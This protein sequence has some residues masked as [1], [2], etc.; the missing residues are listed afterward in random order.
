MQLSKHS[1]L[2]KDSPNIGPFGV[3]IIKIIKI[4]QKATL[5]PYLISDFSKLGV[6]K[7]WERKQVLPNN[8]SK[9]NVFWGFLLQTLHELYERTEYFTNDFWCIETSELS[10]TRF[11]VMDYFFFELFFGRHSGTGGFSLLSVALT[12]NYRQFLC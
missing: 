12:I 8:T 7:F 4:T 10:M 9:Y 2:Q 11:F 1:K 6:E 3:Q 5:S